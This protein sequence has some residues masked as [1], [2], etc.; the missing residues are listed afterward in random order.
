MPG[1]LTASLAPRIRTD[2]A[3]DDSTLGVAVALFYLV[4]A[5]GSI[6]AG[7]LVDRLGATRG[8]RLAAALT[9]ASCLAI[10]ALAAVRSEPDRAAADRRGGERARL[11]DGEH[12]P[13]AGG[14]GAPAG[15]G[16]RRSAGG[17]SARLPARR[18]RSARW[19]R[20]PFGWRWA[21]VAAAALAAFA[22]AFAPREDARTAPRAPAGRRRTGAHLGARPRRGCSAGERRR[23]GLRLVPGDLRGG[24][25]DERDHRG[26]P[27]GRGQPGGHAQQD[28]AWASS[29]TGP[30]SSRSAPVAAM[31]AASVLGYLLLTVG[32]PAAITA[33][34]LLAGTLGWAWPGVLNLA[35][36]Q[37]SPEAPAWAV[38]VMMTGLFAGAITGPAAHRLSG[39]ARSVRGRVDH[40]RG[41]GAAGGGHDPGDAATG[42]GLKP[43]PS[44][45][46]PGSDGWP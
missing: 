13:A 17:R 26:P 46:R 21:F 18:A 2:F 3:F 15:T 9:A 7:R 6:P 8:M 10:A 38:G 30:G 44:S 5:S 45:S 24:Q 16:L 37:R 40:V 31:L 33:A 41:A 12:A 23:R 28:R 34:A 43:A 25:R 42:D 32:E 29:R 4:S 22:V 36:V 27:A 35:V 39:R 20:F 14:R 19:W 11:A 1:F